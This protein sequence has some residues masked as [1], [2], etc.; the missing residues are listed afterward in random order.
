MCVPVVDA[1]AAR[2]RARRPR[3]STVLLL[4]V[5]LIASG[6]ATVQEPASL[7]RD[8]INDVRFLERAVSQVDPEVRVSVAV[9]SAEEVRALLGAD[10]YASEIQPVWLRVEN[11]GDRTWHLISTAMDPNHFSSLEAAYRVTSSFSASRRE[12]LGRHFRAMS[13]KNPVLPSTAVSGFV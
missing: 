7:G 5:I 13:F 6:C 1:R 10:L 4:G 8:V 3:L 11:D 9:P 2:A 12:S